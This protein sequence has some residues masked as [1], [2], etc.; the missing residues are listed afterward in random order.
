MLLVG[1][2]A[3]EGFIPSFRTVDTGIAW[4]KSKIRTKSDRTSWAYPISWSSVVSWSL[5]TLI[6]LAHSVSRCSSIVSWWCASGHG[7][8]SSRAFLI[9]RKHAAV[10]SR[11]LESMT[12]TLMIDQSA[13]SGR[14]WQAAWRNKLCFSTNHIIAECSLSLPALPILLEFFANHPCC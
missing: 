5:K 2:C 11:T 14:C 1:S 3:D 4:I 6:Q 8:T 7:W 9:L 12:V 10:A 13:R